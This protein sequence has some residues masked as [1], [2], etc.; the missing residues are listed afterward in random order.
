M[1]PSDSSPELKKLKLYWSVCLISLK[2]SSISTHFDE[3]SR[4]FLA[5]PLEGTVFL[6]N[7]FFRHSLKSG[8][9]DLHLSS[10][11][12]IQHLIICL[13]NSSIISHAQ[14]KHIPIS[15]Q[16]SRLLNEFHISQYS[17]GIRWSFITYFISI[18][19]GPTDS[20]TFI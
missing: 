11:L 5:L 17:P 4:L 6:I 8:E 20:F 16:A 10:A 9:G 19:S 3:A 13:L 15:Q 18:I 14:R 7:L 1:V 12:S 2:W